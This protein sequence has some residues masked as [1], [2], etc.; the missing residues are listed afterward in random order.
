M[1]LRP[2]VFYGG[3]R[4]EH[5]VLGVFANAQYEIVDGFFA[6]RDSGLLAVTSYA[7][8]EGKRICRRGNWVLVVG[9]IT[10]FAWGVSK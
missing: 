3:G 6:N 2:P 9:I 4:Q 10:W 7:G 1:N 8:F 5:E